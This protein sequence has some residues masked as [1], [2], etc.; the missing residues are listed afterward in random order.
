MRF[1]FVTCVVSGYD[2][3]IIIG[4]RHRALKRY[5][6]NDDRRRIP[7]IHK[8]NNRRILAHPGEVLQAQYMNLPG[9]E[10]HPLKGDLE[11]HWL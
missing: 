2:E 11:N 10:L 4:L 7:T 8:D 3:S 5:L 6:K 9:F 1:Q